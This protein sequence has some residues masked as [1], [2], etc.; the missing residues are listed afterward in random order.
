MAAHWAAVLLLNLRSLR[1]TFRPHEE[2]SAR[3]I[4]DPACENVSSTA[5]GVSLKD[6]TDGPKGSQPGTRGSPCFA[7]ATCMNCSA[8]RY[9]TGCRRRKN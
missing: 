5:L 6:A 3:S 9:D 8:V 2:A 4:A 1:A 7:Y